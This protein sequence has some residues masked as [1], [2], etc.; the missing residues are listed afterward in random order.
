MVDYFGGQLVWSRGFN[1]LALS[2]KHH[3]VEIVVGVVVKV[4]SSSS[5]ASLSGSVTWLGA[6]K[7]ARFCSRI[8]SSSVGCRATDHVARAGSGKNSI[9]V[10]GCC[11]TIKQTETGLIQSIS[12]LNSTPPVKVGERERVTELTRQW[13]IARNLKSTS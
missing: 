7:A 8:Q 9:A 3:R 6:R 11:Y 12:W 1:V 2:L 13:I 10:A 4:V 5:R